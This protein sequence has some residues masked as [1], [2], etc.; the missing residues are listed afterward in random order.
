MGRIWLPLVLGLLI[1]ALAAQIYYLNEENNQLTKDKTALAK[2]ILKP[3][4]P[5]KLY[6]FGCKI[7]SA[8]VLVFSNGNSYSMEMAELRKLKK[9]LP[10]DIPIIT[11]QSP[12]CRPPGT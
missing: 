3:S 11:Y 1:S 9:R 7:P 10:P 12:E 2:E 5:K 4:V 8:A 6:I